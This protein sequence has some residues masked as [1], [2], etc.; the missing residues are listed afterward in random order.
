[1][2]YF[3]GI[4]C[5]PLSFYNDYIA[6]INGSNFSQPIKAKY[7]NEAN[8]HLGEPIRKDPKPLVS[9]AQQRLF[10]FARLAHFQLSAI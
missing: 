1:M 2:F 9:I 3:H 6:F 7:A 10:A 5:G 4:L 8:G